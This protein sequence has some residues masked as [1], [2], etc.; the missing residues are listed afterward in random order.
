MVFWISWV[1]QVYI[2]PALEWAYMVFLLDSIVL[3]PPCHHI[4][5]VMFLTVPPMF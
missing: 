3:D 1:N 5:S 2:S 4:T